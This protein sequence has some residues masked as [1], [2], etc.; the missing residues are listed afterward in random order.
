MFAFIIIIIIKKP[1]V[2]TELL[3]K[4][5]M[6]KQKNLSLIGAHNDTRITQ[7]V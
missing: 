6:I 5:M 4:V 7:G 1:T 3:K 2:W